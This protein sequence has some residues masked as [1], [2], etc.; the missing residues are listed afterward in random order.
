[1][2]RQHDL[3]TLT[4]LGIVIVYTFVKMSQAKIALNNTTVNVAD[5]SKLEGKFLNV[6]FICGKKK[7]N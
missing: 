3:N 2:R 1:M 7:K 6:V 5:F 4:V